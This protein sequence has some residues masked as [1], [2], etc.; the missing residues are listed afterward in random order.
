MHIILFVPQWFS[1]GSN[2]CIGLVWRR[3]WY[4]N[5]VEIYNAT[6]RSQWTGL[7][8]RKWAFLFYFFIMVEQRKILRN[9]RYIA[10]KSQTVYRHAHTSNNCNF[11]QFCYL[12][13]AV[14]IFM[15]LSKGD[16][17]YLHDFPL[18]WDWDFMCQLEKKE[19][20][21]W[22]IACE[23]ANNNIIE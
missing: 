9:S 8:M 4:C 20:S 3:I 13:C 5:N 14:V 12:W 18:H 6:N 21:P 16:I 2:I 22:L 17:F 23:H 10:W 11:F 7:L 15:I 19:I 1:Q